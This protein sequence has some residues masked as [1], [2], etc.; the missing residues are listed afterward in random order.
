MACSSVSAG[1]NRKAK[2][3]CDCCLVIILV[4]FP[5]GGNV[6]KLLVFSCRVISKALVLL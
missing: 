3:S 2:S 4:L 6:A 5:V 1:E